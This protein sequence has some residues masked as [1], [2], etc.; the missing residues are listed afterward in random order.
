[1]SAIKRRLRRKGDRLGEFLQCKVVIFWIF[2]VFV[3]AGLLNCINCNPVPRGTRNHPDE[4]S[5][6]F[7]SLQTDSG[8]QLDLEIALS[9]VSAK[10]QPHGLIQPGRRCVETSGDV[11]EGT[12]TSTAECRI[13]DFSPMRSG[14]GVNDPTPAIARDGAAVAPR[15]AGSTELVSDD[16]PVFHWWHDAR[17]S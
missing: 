8:L 13:S 9:G 10:V 14:T 5:E 11:I 15:P 3:E 4:A 17:F 16:L 7:A 12:F 2:I 6:K 1:M